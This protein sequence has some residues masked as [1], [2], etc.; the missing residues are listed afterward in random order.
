ME[1][2]PG[3]MRCLRAGRTTILEMAN[4]LGITL[5]ARREYQTVAGLV[6][7]HF[8]ATTRRW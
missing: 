6:L 5:P 1:P 7:V 4:R 8:A 2:L 3:L